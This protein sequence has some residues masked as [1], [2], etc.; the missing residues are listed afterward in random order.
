M[1]SIHNYLSSDHRHCDEVLA[2][3]ESTIAEKR[4]SDASKR[5]SEFTHDMLRHLKCEEEILFPAFEEE[6][7]MSGGPVMVMKMEH[8]QMREILSEIPDALTNKNSDRLLGLTETLM[9]LVQQHNSKE[10]QILYNMCDMH[11]SGMA[12]TLIEKMKEVK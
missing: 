5:L 1:S 4:W 12:T 2:S 9:I 6:T 10:E 7:G 11:L 3:L 8:E